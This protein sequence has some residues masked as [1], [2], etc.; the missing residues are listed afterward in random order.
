MNVNSINNINFRGMYDPNILVTGGSGYIGTHLVP[1]LVKDNYNCIICCRDKLQQEYLTGII[2]EINK[3]KV[4]KSLC[5]FVD[6]D[7][8]DTEGIKKVIKNVYPVDSVV[9]LAGSTYNS[10][11]LVNPRKYYANNVLASNNLLNAMLDSN[12]DKLLYISTSSIYSD[13]GSH[14]LKE[15]AVI[16]PKTP[17]SGT[18]YMTE[19]MVQ[20]YKVHGL[21]FDILRLFNV[22]GA[23]GDTDSKIGKNFITVLMNLVKENGIFTLMGNDYPTKDGTCVKDFIHID[24]VVSA[25]RKSVG[26]LLSGEDGGVYNLGSGK[27]VSLGE[28]IQ[29]VY[30]IADR[31]VKLRIVP[32]LETEIPVIIADNT[33][34]RQKLD[35]VPKK[36]IDDILH[37]VWNW[38]IKHKGIK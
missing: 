17:Y 2:D 9:H 24:D 3:G 26:T 30:K 6:I 38:T 1:E 8:Q 32:K 4:D 22:A 7:L 16:A 28:I 20:D 13:N 37:S 33:K 27:G 15:D 31:D 35:W 14:P 10:E 21:K 29:K 12:V 19:Q 25:I 23:S 36:N 11:S 18:K 34:L 5:S